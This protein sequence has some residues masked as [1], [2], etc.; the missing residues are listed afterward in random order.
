MPTIVAKFPKR[1]K[2]MDR[3]EICATLSLE[4]EG[5]AMLEE[6]NLKAKLEKADYEALMPALKQQLAALDAPLRSAG[7]PVIILFEGRS[8]AGKGKMIGRLIKNLDPRWFKVVNTQ[9][10]TELEQR[11]PYLRRHWLTI[12]EEGMFSIMDRSW[13]QEVSVRAIADKLSARCVETRLADIRRFEKTL[14]DNGYL[15]LKFFLHI[16]KREMKARLKELSENPETAFRVVKSDRKQLSHYE[17]YYRAFDRMIEKTQSAEAPWTLVSG[18]DSRAA[19]VQVFRTV[20][21]AVQARLEE[22]RNGESENISLPLPASAKPL[23]LS[24]VDL[25]QSLTREE[26]KNCLEEEKARLAKNQNLLYLKRIPLVVGFEGWD[27]AGKG[28]CIKRLSSP[29]D[30][31]GYAAL[32]IASP[33][34]E[35]K[36]RHFLWRF[37]ARLPKSGHIAIFDRTWYGRVLVERIEGFCSEADW[38]RA[39]GEINDFESYLA[40][41]GTLVVKFWIHISK[42]EQ[43]KRFRARERT[44]EKQ[45]KI[46]AEDW[47]NREKWAL[48]ETAV[49]DM[50]RYTSTETAPWH[51]LAGNDKYFARIQALRIVNEAIEAR[52]KEKG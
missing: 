31:R 23:S 30:A 22:R 12:P 43:L 45:W 14:T 36:K 1:R 42:D 40:A 3:R 17:D 7:L 29:L 6:V 48:Y 46:T 27:A 37:Y 11:Y 47:R 18:M 50:L 52:L 4:S 51:I 20:I 44:P 24:E 38:K 41:S 26:Y 16:S 19:A 39:Y 25:T 8:A 33:T 28:G 13:Y 15:I 10:P 9:A 35:E 32:P 5:Y 2:A 34:P 49:N 21:D